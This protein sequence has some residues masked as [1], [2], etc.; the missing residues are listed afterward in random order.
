MGNVTTAAEDGGVEG[1]ARWSGS[2][3]RGTRDALQNGVRPT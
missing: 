3:S 1:V 2:G